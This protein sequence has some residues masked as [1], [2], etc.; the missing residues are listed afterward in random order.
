[1]FAL[2]F[3][4]SSNTDDDGN[5]NTLQSRCQVDLQTPNTPTPVNNNET[6]QQP[7]NDDNNNNNE[8]SQ[9]TRQEQSGSQRVR[10]AVGGTGGQVRQL[11]NWTAKTETVVAVTVA[12][13]R[14]LGLQ[15]RTF[16]CE[17]NF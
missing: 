9:P 13:S 16:E 12:K 5:A 15:L 10:Q 1:L 4:F 8:P 6:T 7:N 11:D 2:V 17:Y 3:H 14:Q